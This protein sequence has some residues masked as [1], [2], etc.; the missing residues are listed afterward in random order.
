MSIV[1][2]SEQ[3][4]VSQREG[5]SAAPLQIAVLVSGK[6]RGTNL[7]ALLAACASGQIPGRIAVVIGTRADAPAME[8]AR[9]AGVDA[10]VLS[11]RK[12]EDDEAGYAD[13]LLRALQRRNVGLICLAGYMRKLPLPVIE[14]YRGRIMNVH[15][16]LLPLF[17]GQGMYG[18]HVH[19]AVLESGMKVSGCTVHFVDEQY[20]TGPII[21]Q[22]AVPVLEEDTPETLAARVLPE[23]HRAYV[24]AV[25]LFAQGRLRLEGRRVRVLPPAS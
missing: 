23:E 13:A 14:A 17:G 7:G 5:A 4:T 18:E 15:A 12:Y 1:Q 22:T 11:P 21:V 6:G 2:Q 10:V 24:R 25:Q 3:A 20:D 16:A 9:E 8:R 19:R